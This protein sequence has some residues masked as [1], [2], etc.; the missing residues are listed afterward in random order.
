MVAVLMAATAIRAEKMPYRCELGLQGGTSYYVGDAAAHIFMH[1]REAYG[2][3]FRY[4]FTNRWAL[5]VKGQAEHIAFKHKGEKGDNR[6]ASVDAVGEFNFF[7]FGERT[8][9]TRI[10]PWTPYIFLGLGT[11]LYA[12]SKPYTKAA[13][14]LP[15]GVGIKWKFSDRL[16]IQAAWQHNL[17][18]TDNL[19]AK[20][21]LDNTYKLNGSNILNNDLTGTV[22]FGIVFEFLQQKRVCRTC[23]W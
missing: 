9:D 1:P 17:Y 5:Q 3:Q 10:K 6:L 22:T 16:G 15:F 14:Y 19:E 7:R 21:E 23:R 4:K 11:S 2:A 8:Y 20:K 13:V 18:F 12:G